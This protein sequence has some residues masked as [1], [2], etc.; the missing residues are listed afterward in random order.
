MMDY[1]HLKLRRERN[2][3]IPFYSF[4]F[5]PRSFV[6]MTMTSW[7]LNMQ[8][9]PLLPSSHTYTPRMENCACAAN[10]TLSCECAL[11][12]EEDIQKGE[13]EKK[14]V[15]TQIIPF[16][17]S[18]DSYHYCS[19]GIGNSHESLPSFFSVPAVAGGNELNP[20]CNALSE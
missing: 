14:G 13:G 2:K 4:F 17:S 19:R 15:D 1:I 7:L 9:Y 3:L 12:E 18:K 11:P 16:Y 20:S 6:F 8:V 10:Q 5:S